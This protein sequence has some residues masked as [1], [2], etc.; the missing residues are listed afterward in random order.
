MRIVI[1][2]NGKV[3]N[4]LIDFLSKEGHD[5]TIIDTNAKLIDKVTNDY[6]V[7]G[8]CGNGASYN[9]QMEAGVDKSHLLIAVTTTDELNILCCMIAKKI[10]ARHTIARVRNPEYSQQLL[11]MRNELGIS[12]MINPEYESANEISKMLRFPSALKL[13][14]FAKGRVDLAEIKIKSGSL[15]IN[16]PVYSLNKIFKSRVIVCVVQRGDKVYIPKGDFVLEEGDKLNI[17]ASHADLNTFLKNVGIKKNHKIKNVMIVGGG[18]IAY[19][20]TK[21]LLELNMHVTIIE[22][23][24]NRCLELSDLLPKAL[25]INA[26]GTDQRVLC[27]QGIG[28]MDAFV[29]LIGIDEE[30]VILSMY[31]DTMNIK[32]VITKINRISFGSVLNSLGIESIVSPKFITANQI[33]RY[34]RAKQNAFGSNINNLYKIVDGKAEAIEF[35][36][37]DGLRIIGNKLKDL[38]LKR[39]I[40]IACIIRK[41]KFIFPTGDDCIMARDIVVVVTT[42][43]YLR[44]I[45]DILE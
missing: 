28:Q 18:K 2:G 8:I 26:D 27:E 20:L 23:D 5:L 17:T 4:V 9:I 3:G 1:I 22:S 6:D 36:A 30:N 10:G 43:Q 29:S 40:L 39:D 15:L 7:N 24:M 34:V 41:N 21:Q 38:N 32:K 33:V 11:F 13:D 42:N 45:D 35:I 44:K 31:A 14:D 19:Y 16:K 12:M 37:T 25:I